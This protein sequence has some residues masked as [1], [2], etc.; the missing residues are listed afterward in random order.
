M[1]EAYLGCKNPHLEKIWL[2]KTDYQFEADLGLA[3]PLYKTSRLF[4]GS[5]LMLCDRQDV[6]HILRTFTSTNIKSDLRELRTK[7]KVLR[8]NSPKRGY[9]FVELLAKVMWPIV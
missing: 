1:D 2:K 3:K 9:R 6:F 7:S 8:P 5:F 4:R